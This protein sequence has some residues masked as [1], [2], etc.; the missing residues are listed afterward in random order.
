LQEGIHEWSN[1]Q[2]LRLQGT[3]QATAEEGDGHTL[4]TYDALHGYLNQ[5]DKEAESRPVQCI[6]FQESAISVE[7]LLEL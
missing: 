1:P 7:M 2:E 4:L 3:C 5:R 6:A